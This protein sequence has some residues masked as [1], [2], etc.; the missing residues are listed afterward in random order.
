M[1]AA[2]WSSGQ[3]DQLECALRPLD[4]DVGDGDDVDA[5]DVVRLGQVHGAVPAG[6][7]ETDAD[8]AAF[9][10]A[11]L[12]K[13]V[14]VHWIVLRVDD[15]SGDEVHER[16]IGSARLPRRVRLQYLEW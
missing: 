13:G 9:A 14:E 2:I 1:S 3:S 11:L 12:K 6:A 16:P 10:F 8:G 7:D 5:R 4:V 15:A